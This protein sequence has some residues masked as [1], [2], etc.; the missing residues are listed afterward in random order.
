MGASTPARISEA[1]Q[2]QPA[3]RRAGIGQAV[4][5]ARQEI[6]ATSTPSRVSVLQSRA[7]KPSLGLSR[8]RKD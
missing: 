1:G 2:R 8:I 7:M 5:D 3:E 4:G 6:Q